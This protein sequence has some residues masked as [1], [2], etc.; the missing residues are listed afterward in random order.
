MI[1]IGF[2]TRVHLF[3]LEIL[4]QAADILNT[5]ETRRHIYADKGTSGYFAEEFGRQGVEER[6]LGQT[7]SKI[8]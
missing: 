2:F 3:L 7:Q 1:L 6:R 5:Y 4:P 8:V